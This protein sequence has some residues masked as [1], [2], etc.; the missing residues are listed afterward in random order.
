MK[1]RAFF[2]STALGECQRTLVLPNRT[3]HANYLFSVFPDSHF[4]SPPWKGI[5]VRAEVRPRKT[6]SVGACTC[7]VL[8]DVHV[9]HPGQASTPASK[10]RHRRPRR[11]LSTHVGVRVCVVHARGAYP[12]K[13]SPSAY[14]CEP[15]SLVQWACARGTRAR[16]APWKGADVRVEVCANR[17]C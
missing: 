4:Q 13:P 11:S 1:T 14:K 7:A 5:N 9:L 2:K 15:S 3:A 8:L 10:F 17:S 12:G 6:G 16:F